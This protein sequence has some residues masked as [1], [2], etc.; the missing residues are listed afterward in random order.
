M[1]NI[2]LGTTVLGAAALFAG[3]AHAETPKV[4]LGGYADFQAGFVGEDNDVNKRAGAFRSDD[5]ITFRIDGKSDAG[6]GYGAAIDLH[7]DVSDNTDNAKDTGGTARR[8]YVYLDGA[9]GRVQAG[10]DL[11]VTNTMKIGAESIAHGTG[12]IDGDW[13]YF[14]S[15]TS[16]NVISTPDLILDHGSFGQF[17]DRSAE[18]INKVS[19]Y[20]PR[21]AG[22]QLGVSY[23]FDTNTASRGEVLSRVDNDNGQAQNVIL[24]GINYEGKFSDVTVGA[25]ATGEFGNAEVNTYNDLRTYNVGAK[26]GYMGFSLAGS[27]G[28][29]GDSLRLKSVASDSSNHY[30]TVGGAYETG[31]FG[32]SVT[33]LNSQY[34][35][36]TT[37]N[38]FSNLSFS[39]DYKL[40]PGLT[41]YAEVDF[42]NVDPAGTVDDNKATVFL[43]GTQVQF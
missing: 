38:D 7:A 14:V 8:T 13:T 34:D 1:K 39:T 36:G 11:G 42:V 2:L 15:P 28:N 6:L 16:G 17:S 41:P 40:A 31:P 18:N 5:V 21:F 4:T 43:L 3:V 12:G 22:V 20:T 32:A 30:W 26:V 24:G 23:L 37:H 29:L 19:Y 35:L 10:S 9:W 25:A 33:Y 27:Y